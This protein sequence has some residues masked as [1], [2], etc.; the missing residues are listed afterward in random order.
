MVLALQKDIQLLQLVWHPLLPGVD[1]ADKQSFRTRRLLRGSKVADEIEDFRGNFCEKLPEE[2]SSVSS[3]GLKGGARVGS[4]QAS[5][6]VEV[7]RGIG[8]ELLRQILA[9]DG[10]RSLCT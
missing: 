3:S 5:E 9:G 8:S 7:S 6:G 10:Q 1:E 2:K 4:R